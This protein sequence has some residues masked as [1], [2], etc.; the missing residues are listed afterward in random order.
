MRNNNNDDDD[1]FKCDICGKTYSSQRSLNAHRVGHGVGQEELEKKSPWRSI[2]VRFIFIRQFTKNQHESELNLLKLKIHM[3]RKIARIGLN[4]LTISKIGS[5]GAKVQ[6]TIQLANSTL[7]LSYFR[8]IT[9]VGRLSNKLED[10]LN[11]TKS[12]T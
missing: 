6:V 12:F 9:L 7:A 4:Y 2:Q 10:L 3:N 1:D 5:I 8:P 11:S